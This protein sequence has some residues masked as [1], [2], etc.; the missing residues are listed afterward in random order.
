MRRPPRRTAA[1]VLLLPPLLLAP[2]APAAA[3]EGDRGERCSQDRD[4]EDSDHEGPGLP[5]THRDRVYVAGGG[6]R[7]EPGAAADSP[8]FWVY[9][10]RDLLAALREP[11][12]GAVFLNDVVVGPDG[13]A[14]VTDSVTPRIFRIAREDGEW[15]ANLWASPDAP[16]A[17]VQGEGFGLNGIEVAPD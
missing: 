10:D 9:D 8:D 16:G 4:H 14:Y 7:T 13:M 11:A 17:P 2:A 12:E 6:N 1:A 15:R 3:H 5:A